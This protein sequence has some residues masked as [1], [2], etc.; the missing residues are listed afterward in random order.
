MSRY[1]VAAAFTLLLGAPALAQNQSGQSGAGS[2][3]AVQ[4][5]AA[6]AACDKGASVPLEQSATEPPIQYN[7]LISADF[8]TKA[9]TRVSAACK[10]AFLGALGTPDQKR[11]KLEWLRTVIALGTDSDYMPFLSDLRQFAASGSAEANYLLFEIYRTHAHAD[12]GSPIS[13]SDGLAAARTAAEAGHQDALATILYEY[14]TGPDLRRDPKEVARFA[15]ALMNLPPQGKQPG[16]SEANARKLG[17]VLLGRTLVTADGFSAAEQAKGFAIVKEFYDAKEETSF[18]PYVT[19]LRYGRGTPQDAAAARQ[20]LEDAVTRDVAPAFPVLADMLANGEGGPVDGKRALALL[21]SDKA[22]KAAATKPLLAE[23]YLDNRFTG[24]RPREAVQLLIAGPS[25]IDARIK[26]AALL[27]E[28]DEKLEVPGYFSDKLA[29]AAEAGEPGAAMALARLKLSDNPQFGNDKEGARALLQGLASDGDQE[30]ALLLAETQYDH[31][32]DTSFKPNRLEGGMSDGEIRRTVDDGIAKN[33]ASAYRVKAKLLRVGV[34]YPQDDAAATEALLEAAKRGDIESMILLG[35]AYDDG[36]GV[37]KSPRERLRWW[38]EAARLGSVDAQQRIADAFTFDTFDKLITLREGVS[39]QIALYNNSAGEHSDDTLMGGVMIEA[40]LSGLFSFGS[41]AAE[42][43][44]AALAAAVMDGFR[45]APAGLGEDRLLPLM[46]VIPDEVRIEIEKTLKAD[47]FYDGAP[48]GN[49]GPEVRKA[50]ADWV[51]AKG[52]IN[53]TTGDGGTASAEPEKPAVQ[54]SAPGLSEAVVDRIRDRIFAAAKAAKTDKQK[55]A[56]LR[57]I[58]TLARQGDLASRW[59]LVRNYHTG[60]VVRQAVSPEEITRYGLDL[61]VA[62]PEGMDKVEF[63]F[64]FDVTQ[65]FEDKKSAALG[66]AVLA[67]IQDDVRLQDPLTL[68]AVMGQM[69]FAPGACDAVAATAAKAGIEGLGSDGC[70]ETSRS[71]LI[72]YAKEKGPAGVDAEAR[73]AAAAELLTM[74]KGG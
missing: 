3:K 54:P 28:Y 31:L 20:L 60:K 35:K 66:K 52:P 53:D 47:G 73:K 43:G 69:I 38:R 70:D 2:D 33:L 32:S 23:L 14:L 58:N 41:R 65:V 72:A 51:E 15:E 57:Q 50:L 6:I 12:G 17:K 39:E 27:L 44:N 36:I 29:A 11:L 25:N 4:L 61:V 46:R 48:K 13:R 71:A 18:V 74:D 34:I 56:A 8:D 67:A 19:A 40:H 55:V 62:R 26:A 1:I 7:E 64:I 30:A 22:A 24:P 45:I 59:V 68:G 16:A 5:R 37:E 21:R 63:E 9:L 42:G 10:E 49:F